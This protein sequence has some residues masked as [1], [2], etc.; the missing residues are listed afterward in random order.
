[1][2]NQS[3]KLSVG[4]FISLTNQVLDTAYPTVEIEGEV[5]GFKVNQDK[6]IFFD[7]KDNEGSI[8]C[9]MMKFQLRIVVEDGMKVIVRAH[10]KL[11]KWGKFS[12]TIDQIRPVG[13]GAIK[14]NFELL[15]KKLNSEGLFA[16]ERKRP[17]PP[18]PQ[19]IAVISSMQAAGYADFMKII[20]ARWGGI[21]IDVAHVQ[22]QGMEAPDQIIRALTY[23]SQQERLPEVIVLI[24]GGGSADDLA[25]F[26]D[27]LLVRQ[28]AASR[29]PVLTGIGHEIDE[30]LV[31]L[32]ADVR[33]S[34]PSNAAEL[35]VPDRQSILHHAEAQ[36]RHIVMRTNQVIAEID[37]ERRQKLQFMLEK[38]EL[39]LDDAMGR[40][41]QLEAVLAAFNPRRVLERGY[42]I[43][44]GNVEVGKVIEVETKEQ[45][46]ETEVRNVREK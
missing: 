3:L 14:R 6:F 46:I 8:G 16:S 18:M 43:V 40:T 32:A 41:D 15:Y 30:T 13:E 22:V 12:L 27:E 10:P 24:R 39:S 37:R 5:S 28:V 26:N 2:E 44:R 29:V 9:F 1:M 7:L 21:E 19:H 11:T 35:L 42:A 31:D 23:I 38:I 20:D 17:L 34:T 25:A 4:E 33:A 36:L 45:F